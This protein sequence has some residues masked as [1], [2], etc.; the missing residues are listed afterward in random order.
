MLTGG[1]GPAQA[2][3]PAAKAQ[4]SH[5]QLT[6]PPMGGERGSRLARP[7]AAK[8]CCSKCGDFLRWDWRE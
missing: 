3:G 1:A 8:R 4:S 5:P 7:H 6:P 2:F